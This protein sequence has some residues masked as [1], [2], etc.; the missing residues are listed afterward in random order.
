[1]RSTTCRRRRSR[2]RCSNRSTSSRPASASPRSSSIG[3]TAGSRARDRAAI[4]E[5]RR[6]FEEAAT[7]GR[8]PAT[9]HLARPHDS[10]QCRAVQDHGRGGHRH[11]R[12]RQGA[13]S[14]A[15]RS[16]GAP[17]RDHRRG[18]F[19]SRRDRRVRVDQRDAAGRYRD[20][21]LRPADPDLP[22]P[23]LLDDPVPLGDRR[24]G[25]A[26]AGSATC[27]RSSASP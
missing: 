23:D 15:R 20:A 17:G 3:A 6:Q 12:C 10:A 1:M 18:R 27:S 25:D 5:D 19:R 26:R 2:S 24:R 4:A 9:G 16:A 22:Q 14:R 21:R 13:R 7:A 11:P 8:P